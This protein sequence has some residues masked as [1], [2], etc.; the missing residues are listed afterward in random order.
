MSEST[1][2]ALTTPPSQP[3][4]RPRVWVD[5]G[6]T[7]GKA[8]AAGARPPSQPALGDEQ[9]AFFHTNGYLVLRDV[10]DDPTLDRFESACRLQPPLDQHVPNQTYPGPGR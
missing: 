9:L 5:H 10:F 6:I 1:L 7:A 8:A 4:N 2:T 3:A